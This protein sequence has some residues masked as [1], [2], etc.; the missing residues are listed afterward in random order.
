MLYPRLIPSLLINSKKELVKTKVFKN[1]HYIGDPLNAAYIFSG[2]EADELFVLDIDAS[3]NKKCISLDF[4][5]SLSTFTKVPLTVGGGI[6]NLNQINT[7]LSLG[8]E[9][10]ALS[11]I[12]SEDFNLLQKAS[13]SYGASS[14]TVVINSLRKDNGKIVGYFGRPR[15]SN[16]SFPINDL[17]KKCQDNGAGEIVINRVDIEGTKQGFDVDLMSS[18]NEKLSIP[19]V[20]LGGCGKLKHI[21]DLISKTRISGIACGSFFVYAEDS[22]EV[23]LS[24]ET[25]SKW[26][27]NYFSKKNNIILK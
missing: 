24:Y 21:E 18:L 15:S 1:Q 5:K 22:Q 19:L 2:F 3:K 17:T 25:A 11:N 20:A 26:L 14:I 13:N 16:I 8:V 10:I 27:K 4:V 23:L 9:K 6:T 12:L 7:I